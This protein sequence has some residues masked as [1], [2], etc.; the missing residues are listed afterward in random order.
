MPII[1]NLYV[2]P[3]E[4]LNEEYL[5]NHNIEIDDELIEFINENYDVL[6]TLLDE[7]YDITN[8]LNERTLFTFTPSKND[9]Y[10]NQRRILTNTEK[11]I[12]DKINNR[13][14]REM[15][16]KSGIVKTERQINSLK[17]QGLIPFGPS[18]QKQKA[19]LE[20]KLLPFMI[21]SPKM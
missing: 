8:I 5:Y 14:I 21:Q 18:L 2:P 15:E 4:I 19:F 20:T 13:R 16:R 11:N 17:K 6:Q 12:F 7:G 10:S 3:R 9:G 1:D